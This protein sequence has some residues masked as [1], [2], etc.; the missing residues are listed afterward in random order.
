M[1]TARVIPGRFIHPWNG[2]SNKQRGCGKTPE[3]FPPDVMK[4]RLALTMLILVCAAGFGSPAW[5]DDPDVR[6]KTFSLSAYD[7]KG[8]PPHK[9]TL[10]DFWAEWCTV[11]REYD[12]KI[13]SDPEIAA[14]LNAH[15]NTWR[16]DLTRI[17]SNRS[18]KISRR[19]NVQ[20]VPLILLIDDQGQEYRLQHLVSKEEFLHIIKTG[21]NQ[22]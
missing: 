21:L 22:K 13:F 17:D 2:N 18:A 6:W 8:L 19:F 5:A 10:I 12:Q 15:V 1:F 11:C 7:A 16:C 20:G 4:F 3:V 14:L 9:L